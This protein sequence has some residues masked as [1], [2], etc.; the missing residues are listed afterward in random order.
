MHEPV[1]AVSKSSST[2]GKIP[3]FR[4]IEE[5]S[6]CWWLSFSEKDVKKLL[7]I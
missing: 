3:Q 4:F 5:I 6:L 7:S 2:H 1:E